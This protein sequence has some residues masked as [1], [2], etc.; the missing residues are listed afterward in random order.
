MI[1]LEISKCEHENG[2]FLSPIFGTPQKNG[3]YRL[4][5][6][7]KHLNED[8]EYCQYKLETFADI[9]KLVKSNCY[10][11]SLDIKDAYLCISQFQP[12]PSPG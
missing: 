12:G 3:G 11:A 8:A 1:D 2:E 10:M 4:I 7:L 9:L 5:L 6:N